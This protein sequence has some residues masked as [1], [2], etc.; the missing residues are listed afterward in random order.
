LISEYLFTSAIVDL[1]VEKIDLWIHYLA[2]KLFSYP[3]LQ[4]FHMKLVAFQ[5]C[6]DLFGGFPDL[7]LS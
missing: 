4:V 1:F 3:P 5:L 2:G 7:L 6:G